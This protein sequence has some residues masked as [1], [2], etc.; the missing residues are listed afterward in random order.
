MQPEGNILNIK[1]IK[2]YH[3]NISDVPY[4]N[5]ELNAEWV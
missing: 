3:I 1:S 5:N 2:Q 4:F